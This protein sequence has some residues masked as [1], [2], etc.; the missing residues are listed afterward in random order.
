MNKSSWIPFIAAAALIGLMM[1]TTIRDDPE[2]GIHGPRLR[3][4][5]PNMKEKYV[6]GLPAD[7]L[8]MTVSVS[9]AAD[10]ST[11]PQVP[12]DGRHGADFIGW[13]SVAIVCRD[14]D[15]LTRLLAYGLTDHL[16]P[17]LGDQR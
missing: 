8:R 5:L 4:G 15:Y 7:Q 2:H 17:I 16:S 9:E 1:L 13:Q 11:A 12:T 14:D 6:E 10:Q 3:Y